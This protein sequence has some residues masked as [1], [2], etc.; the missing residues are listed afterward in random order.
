VDDTISTTTTGLVG[1]VGQVLVPPRSQG[2]SGP[3]SPPPS[4]GGSGDGSGSLPGAVPPGEAAD[5]P[6][7]AERKRKTAPPAARIADVAAASPEVLEPTQIIQRGSPPRVGARD[8]GVA[9]P[10]LVPPMR[11]AA[12]ST[13]SSSAGGAPAFAFVGF[14]VIAGLF[15]LVAPGLGR[16]LKLWPALIRPLAFVSP[17]ERPG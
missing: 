8:G 1:T 2:S 14:A 9:V 11:S 12:P 17:P 10:S 7:P 5:T 16:R 3:T 4:T 13:G 6:A 15:A